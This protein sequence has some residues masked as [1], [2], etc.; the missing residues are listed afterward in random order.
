MYRAWIELD[1]NALEHNIK[2]IQ[3]F[4]APNCKIMGVL[5]A[6]AYGHGAPIIARALQEIGIHNFAVATMEEGIELR[7]AGIFGQI[8]ILGKTIPNRVND[9]LY[10]RLSQTIVSPEY[11]K[12]LEKALRTVWADTDGT[13]SDAKLSVHIGIDTGMHRIGID[14]RDISAIK[15][16]YNIPYFNVDGIYSHLCVCDTDIPDDISFSNQQ[17]G[18]YFHVI[19]Q[20]KSDG[21]DLKGTHLQSSY[22][23]VNY[24]PLD[25]NYARLGILMFGVK[26]SSKDYFKHDVAL[27]PVMRLCANVTSVRTVPTGETVGYGRLFRAERP[28]RI[29]SVGIGYGDGIPRRLGNGKLRVL[30]HGQYAWVVG[31]ICMDQ[32]M[33]DV[34]DIPDVREG[35]IVTLIGKDGNNMLVAEEMAGRAGTITNE[36]LSNLSAR[37]ENHGFINIK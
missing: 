15:E 10:Y 23:C 37:I 12:H 7:Q 36:I 14:Y 31:R 29:A 19:N 26:S 17:I 20:L 4:L 9:L 2:S 21:I 6:N 22:A 5:K 16:V 11:A 35:D 24:T 25:C 1:R 3:Y 32:L 13:G 34:T 8:L 18:R 27:Q 33:I 30:L 28:T